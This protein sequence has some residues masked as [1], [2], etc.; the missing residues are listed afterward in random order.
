MRKVCEGFY[1]FEALGN[2][3]KLL[4]QWYKAVGFI[5]KPCLNSIFISASLCAEV[6]KDLS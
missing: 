1:F 3:G 6:L 5:E 2:S 4:P